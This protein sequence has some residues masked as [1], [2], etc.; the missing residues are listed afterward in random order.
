MEI[1]DSVLLAVIQSLVCPLRTLPPPGVPRKFQEW[2]RIKGPKEGQQDRRSK[3]SLVGVF[4]LVWSF[5]FYFLVS[6]Y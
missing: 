4:L 1:V 6:L 3:V 5:G 2:Q